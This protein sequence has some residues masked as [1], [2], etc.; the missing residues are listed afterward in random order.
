MALAI[1]LYVGAYCVM[2]QPI[3]S[4]P[5]YYVGDPNDFRWYEEVSP[6]MYHGPRRI[7]Q[8]LFAP[9]HWVDR[10]LR[11]RTWNPVVPD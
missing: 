11:H 4:I 6:G 3:G 8:Q 2:V 10:R 5:L 9:I 7:W 1:G